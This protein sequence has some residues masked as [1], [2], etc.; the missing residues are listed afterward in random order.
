MAFVKMTNEELEDINVKDGQDSKLLSKEC[1]NFTDYRWEFVSETI[2]ADKS[3]FIKQY[4]NKE[5]DTELFTIQNKITDID[6]NI[7]FSRY[8]FYKEV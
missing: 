5:D 7:V 4:I 3:Q 1:G 8:E 6:G 2:S